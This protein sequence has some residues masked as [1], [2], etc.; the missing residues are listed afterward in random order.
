MLHYILLYLT[1]TLYTLY[2]YIN[3]TLIHH[4]LNALSLGRRLGASDEEAGHAL[5]M[6]QCHQKPPD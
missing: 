5:P 1:I 3:A 2:V 4:D 6:F